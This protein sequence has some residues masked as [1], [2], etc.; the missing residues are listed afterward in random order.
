MASRKGGSEVGHGE[1]KQWAN[2]GVLL[3]NSDPLP[4][5][6]SSNWITFLQF[7]LRP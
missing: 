3:L 1:N 6:F 2:D 7:P 4:S 5:W